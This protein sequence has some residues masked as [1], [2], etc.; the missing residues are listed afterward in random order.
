MIFQLF[1]II[2]TV[3]GV[4][5]GRRIIIYNNYNTEQYHQWQDLKRYFVLYYLGLFS[6]VANC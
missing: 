3:S 5:S 4:I 6:V 1:L 2:H